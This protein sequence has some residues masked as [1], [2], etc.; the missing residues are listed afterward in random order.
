MSLLYHRRRLYNQGRN[1]LH[2]RP[3]ILILLLPSNNSWSKSST[4]CIALDTPGSGQSELGKSEQS[5]ATIAEDAVGLLDTLN[6]KQKIIA[7]GHS[8]GSI[9]ANYLAATYPDRV[10]GVV[11]LGPVNPDLAMVPVFEQRIK[12]VKDGKSDLWLSQ[13]WFFKAIPRILTRK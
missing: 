13:V 9:I 10:R 12:V 1:A 2:P 6:I 7:V 8:L 5:I 4:R 11:L 3:R